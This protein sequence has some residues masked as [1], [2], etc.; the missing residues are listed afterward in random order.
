MELHPQEAQ[1]ILAIRKKYQ[2][3]ELII[4][5]RNGLPE[6]IGKTTT[7]QRLSELELSTD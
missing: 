3:G 7:Y 6:R 5:T 1:L 2:F 4:E